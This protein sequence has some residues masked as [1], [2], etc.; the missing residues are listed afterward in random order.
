MF[1]NPLMPL[2]AIGLLQALMPSSTTA[3]ATP[4]KPASSLPSELSSTSPFANLNLSAGEQSQIA[5]ILRSSQGQP[6]AQ[7]ANS[8]SGVLTSTQRQTFSNDLRSLQTSG[9]HHHHHGSG[10]SGSSTAIDSGTDGFGVASTSS[11]TPTAT[12]A[13][14]LFSDLAAQFSAQSQTQSQSILAG[15]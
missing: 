12:A 6:F 9:S 14:S 3:S 10:G 13:S 11:A 5:A 15:L 4:A 1:M 2:N 7:I 8:I